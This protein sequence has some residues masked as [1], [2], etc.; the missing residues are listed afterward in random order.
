M[1]KIVY[2]Y[3]TN[4]QYKTIIQSIN[5]NYNSLNDTKITPLFKKVP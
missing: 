2:I 3:I 4:D 5:K 1:A